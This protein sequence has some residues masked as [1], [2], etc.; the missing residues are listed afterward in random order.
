MKGRSVLCRGAQGLLLLGLLGCSS[1][2]KPIAT[3]AG[4]CEAI[5]SSPSPNAFV[6]TER[7][8]APESI[9]ADFTAWYDSV[10]TT[11]IAHDFLDGATP[12]DTVTQALRRVR[13]VGVW[14]VGTH[15]HVA[16]ELLF[17]AGDPVRNEVTFDG[18]VA[19]FRE[20]LNLEHEPWMTPE[21]KC[22]FHAI[23]ALF[24]DVTIH[25]PHDSTA[26]IP[27]A[28][29]LKPEEKHNAVGA[30]PLRSR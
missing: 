5:Q 7:H 16:N 20:R 22:L 28:H 17:E 21:E 15:L 24:E 2:V 3:Y 8:F 26:T 14:R 4:F 25:G 23:N 29:Y 10:A 18:V 6:T 11:A 19:T 13:M 1:Q 27:A 9:R 12:R 30:P